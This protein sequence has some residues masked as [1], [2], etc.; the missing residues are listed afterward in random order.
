M[1][2]RALIAAALACEPPLLVAD[3]PTTALDVTIQAEILDLLRDMRE[4]FGLALLLITHD[5]GV[6]ADLAD[7]I[8]VMYAGRIVEEGPTRAVLATPAHPY[9]R[10]LLAS[11]PGAT[12]GA[13]LAAIPG[14][15]PDL[16]ALPPGCAFGP[17]CP[18]HEAACDRRPPEPVAVA[19]GHTARCVRAAE[20]R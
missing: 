9:T 16:A 5:L 14:A 6:V 15:V 13:R 7:R 1:R 19:P 20:A 4:R 3:E 10:A 8:A 11:L 12:P 18:D 2:Q 17:R